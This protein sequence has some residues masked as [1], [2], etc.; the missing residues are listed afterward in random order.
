MVPDKWSHVR[1][2]KIH[3][4][5][6]YAVIFARLPLAKASDMAK[7]QIRAGEYLPPYKGRMHSTLAKDAQE[8][9]G[10]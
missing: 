3:I 5:N 9:M 6:L 7:P 10:N 4:Q 2:P 8:Q 1:P